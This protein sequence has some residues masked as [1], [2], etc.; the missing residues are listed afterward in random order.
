M[1]VSGVQHSDSDIYICMYMYEYIYIRI[2]IYSFQILFS[3]RLLQNIE[4]DSLCYT[5][6]PCWLSAY[7]S[8]YFYVHAGST[9]RSLL[10]SQYLAQCLVRRRCKEIFAE[11]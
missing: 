4:N 7:R 8:Q 3:Y 6:G 10:Y 11:Y 2:Y 9:S 5:V 1:L